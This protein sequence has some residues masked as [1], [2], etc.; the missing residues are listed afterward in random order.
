MSAIHPMCRVMTL[1]VAVP[2][3]GVCRDSYTLQKLVQAKKELGSEIKL[4]DACSHVYK[5]LEKMERW[6]SEIEQFKG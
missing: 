2:I 3:G 1:S 6:I 4:Q 5:Q